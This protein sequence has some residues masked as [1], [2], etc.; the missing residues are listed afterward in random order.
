[1]PLPT[2]TG[3]GRRRF[4]EKKRKKKWRKTTYI[5]IAGLK[6]CMYIKT[7]VSHYS[8]HSRVFTDKSN[9]K[10]TKDAV[11]VDDNFAS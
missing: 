5:N 3:C 4:V 9:I 8:I 1:M 6:I 7:Y 10:P 2:F 11:A